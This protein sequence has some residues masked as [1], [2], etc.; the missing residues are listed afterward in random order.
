M[1][2]YNIFRDTLEGIIAAPFPN[3][4]NYTLPFKRMLIILLL[5]CQSIYAQSTGTLVVTPK[6]YHIDHDLHL[7]L[8]NQP[9]E[10]LS[11]R[12]LPKNNLLVD[13]YYDFQ[14]PITNITVGQAYLVTR[15]GT[16]QSYQL[17]FTELPIIEITPTTTIVDEP[18]IPAQFTFTPSKGDIINSWIG[19]EYRGGS[20]QGLPKKS[21]RL[22]FW[23]DHTASKTKNVQFLDMRTDDDWN[24]QALYNEPLR[25]RN[26]SCHQLWKNMSRLHY[27]DQEPTAIN[28]IEI[29]YVEVFVEGHYQGVFGLSER[30]DRK[31]LQLKAPSSH[32]NRGQLYKGFSWTDVPTFYQVYN[33][34]N[35]NNLLWRGFKHIYPDATYNWKGLHQFCDF[36]VNSSDS[37]FYTDFTK[38]FDLDNAVD[39]FIFLNVVR[40]SDNTGKNIYIAQYDQKEPFYYVAWDLDGSLGN[41]WDGSWHGW[42]YGLLS[43]GMYDR[44]LQDCQPNGFKE[45]L[46]KRWQELRQTIF[47]PAY[48]LRTIELNYQYL[49]RNGVYQR[50]QLAWPAYS[51]NPT[52]LSNLKHWLNNRLIQLDLLFEEECIPVINFDPKDPY[53][54]QKDIL[55]YPTPTTDILYIDYKNRKDA[56]GS[57]YSA[58][59]AFILDFP[60]KHGHQAKDLS[61]LDKGAYILYVNN[62]EYQFTQRILLY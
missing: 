16:T 47:S 45:L 20:S 53:S 9:L 3:P 21:F 62:T 4:V 32:Q 50:E 5:G 14:T 19:I 56:V 59:G 30:I 55:V 49:E 52:H 28:G 17:F 12:G 39:Y 15:Q 58:T 48:L 42:Y 10:T 57:L 29:R 11:N 60:I 46:K 34:Y 31:Q 51:K 37:L 18:S 61:H 38:Y 1:N 2:A 23:K 35:N 54:F 44:L 24:L 7:I 40:A 8:V 25:L 36:V 41:D 22:T 26:K 43:N 33:D 13:R 27:Q 6:Y